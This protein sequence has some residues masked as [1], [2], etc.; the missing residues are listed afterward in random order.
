MQLSQS[1]T[2]IVQNLSLWWLPAEFLLMFYEDLFERCTIVNI[3]FLVLKWVW[4]RWL[5]IYQGKV[6]ISWKSFRAALCTPT[7]MIHKSVFIKC[8]NTLLY[9]VRQINMITTLS[10]DHE[11][12]SKSQFLQSCSPQW[13]GKIYSVRCN[14]Y[15]SWGRIIK[16]HGIWEWKVRFLLHYLLESIDTLDRK[17][18]L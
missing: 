12:P 1:W 6:S 9:W 11:V 8:C 4:L 2:R 7:A 16:F 15:Y 5:N 18:I 13:S 10:I 17:I 14:S 3:F